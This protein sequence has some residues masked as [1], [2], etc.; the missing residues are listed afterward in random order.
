VLARRS[1]VARIGGEEFA[2]VLPEIAYEPALETARK[3]RDA[4]AQVAFK[5]DNMN[6]RITAS[7]GLC[8]VERVPADGRRLAE[9]ILRI[10]DQA[11]YISKHKG[12]NRVSATLFR[13]GERLSQAPSATE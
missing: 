5:V 3:L 8:A 10:A 6:V 12:R 13:P 2:I 9:R 1:W 7:F 4:V 11:L